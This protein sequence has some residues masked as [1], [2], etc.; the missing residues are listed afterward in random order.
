MNGKGRVL[1]W[2]AEAVGLLSDIREGH[3]EDLHVIRLKDYYT[4]ERFT[5]FDDFKDRINAVWLD[6]YEEGWKSGD[7]LDG[8]RMMETCDILIIQNGTGFDFLAIEKALGSFK[9]NHLQSINHELFPFKTADTLVLSQ[10][11]NPERKLHPSAYALG[12]GDTGPHS[13]AAH[14]IRMGRHK[15]E[16]E[17]WSRLTKAMI[18]RVSEDVE[19]GEDLFNYLMNEWD[20]HMDRPN[21]QTGKDI[22]SAYVIEFRMSLA[23][24]YQAMRGFAVDVKF[25]GEL[26]SELDLEI[27]ATEKAFRPHMPMRL[28]MKKLSEEAIEKNAIAMSELGNQFPKAGASSVEWENYMLNGDMRA[29]HAATYWSITTKK[30]EYQKNV[31]K[32]IPEARGFIQD[33]GPNPPVAGPFTPLIWEDIPLGNRDEV[34]QILFKHGWVGVNYNEAETEYIEENNGELPVPWAGK[35]DD[36]S[37]ERWEKSGAT[38]PEWCKGIARW[39]ILS[40]RRTQILNR[41]DVQY[42]RDNGSWPRQANKRNECRGLLA[43]ARCKDAGEYYGKTA[44]EYFEETGSWPSGGHWRVPAEA[45]PCATNTFRM[46][47]KIVVNVPSRGLYGKHMRRMFIAGPGMMLIGCDGSGLELRMLAHFMN[48]PEYTEVIL[49]G[50][51][52]TYNQE[53]A[54]LTTRDLAKTFIYAFLYGSGIPNLA[55]QLGVTFDQMEAAVNK[56]KR[57]MPKLA[58]LLDGVQAAGKKFGYLLA[59]DGRRGRIRSKG[60]TLSLHTA[61]NVLLQ[62]T[63]SLVMKWA[64]VHAEDVALQLEMISSTNDF[65]MVAHQ[66]DEAQ[67]EVCESEVERMEIYIEPTKEAWKAEEKRVHR[68]DDGRLWSAPELILPEKDGEPWLTVRRYHRLGEIYAEAITWAGEELKLRCPTAGEYKIAYSW[69]G[70]H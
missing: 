54:G 48:D 40:S 4:G 3:R 1:T 61:L 29:S 49:N 67:M 42:Y 64:H 33:H 7:I 23:V 60:K 6:E 18:N 50:D 35:I 17:D 27:D 59:V 32:Y 70:T 19:I 2:D 46:R 39:Y 69:E 21:K 22:R 20:D 68:D 55:R 52:H 25:M 28:K 62:M 31:T 37:L 45:F 9:R 12:M 53:K 16:H 36:K 58:A 11:L 63:G 41:K 56:F 51:I 24:A 38:V 14:G 5:F 34:K 57:E 15:P 13:I 65:P 66:H 10:L 26:I 43:R 8:K 47:H 44:Q 30:G